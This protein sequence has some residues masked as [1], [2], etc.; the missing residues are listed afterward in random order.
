MTNL[1]DKIIEDLKN[2]NGGKEDEVITALR[3]KREELGDD[4]SEE[5]IMD[6]VQSLLLETLSEA[7]S[8]DGDTP[9]V[10]TDEDKDHLEKAT[11]TVKE[12][13]DDN[14]W[15]Y[16]TRELRADLV[17]YELGFTVKNTNLR[18]R[19]HVEADPNVCRIDAVLPISADSTYEYPLC[20]V[21]AKENYSKRF[22]SF[23]YDERDGEIIYVHSFITDHGIFKDDLETYFHAVVSTAASSYDDI[24]KCCVGRF[25]A[26]EITEILQ[27]VNAL[28]SDI[29]E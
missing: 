27:K 3:A 4:A 20:K 18:V 11:A 26:N 16:S 22:G 12:F 9:V 10:L 25:K 24:R 28:V 7:S 17:L 8:D 19:I 2:A 13:L 21:L 1:F 14:N 29:S 15:H 6:A 5:D 23:K